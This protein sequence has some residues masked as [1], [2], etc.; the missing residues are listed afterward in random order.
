MA[1]SLRILEGIVL[2]T[3]YEGDNDFV[4]FQL[5]GETGQ[6]VTVIGNKK[7]I[8]SGETLRCNGDWV[9]HSRYGLQFKASSIDKIFKSINQDTPVVLKKDNLAKEGYPCLPNDV[10]VN[11]R[12]QV[13]LSDCN[14]KQNR[15][16]EKNRQKLSHPSR[17]DSLRQLGVG[18]KTA[19]RILDYF[20]DQV[21]NVIDKDPYALTRIAGI[22][23][24][25]ADRIALSYGLDPEDSKRVM[26][27]LRFI[28]EEAAKAGST[29]MLLEKLIEKTAI[30]TGLTAEKIAM[31]LL[32]GLGEKMLVG[33]M[34]GSGWC[35]GLPVLSELEEKIAQNIIAR[36]SRPQTGPDGSLFA[37]LKQNTLW[38]HTLD[39]IASHLSVLQRQAVMMAMQENV[40]IITGGPGTG[41]STLIGALVSLAHSLCE[42]VVVCAP[43][44]RA[45]KRLQETTGLGAK[46]I[47]RL[48]GQAQRRIEADLVIIDEASMLDIYLAAKLLQA[49]P[50]QT[51]MV[52]V[53]DSDQLPS[54][55]PG[56]VF[57]D[58]IDAK[59]FPVFKL[60]EVFRQG[61]G[62]PIIRA[63]HQVNRGEMPV[64]EDSQE[65]TWI[66]S[67]RA[68]QTLE[69]LLKAFALLREEGF[70]DD[71]I[72][73]LSPLH[74]GLLGCRHLNDIFQEVINPKGQVLLIGAKSFRTGERVM[75][76]INN[77]ELELYNGDMGRILGLQDDCLRAVFDD[78]E[79]LLPEKHCHHLQQAYCASVHRV[80]GSEFPAVIF[81]VVSAHAGILC[82]NLV[83][84]AM[85]RAKKRL[86]LI[87]EKRALW[88]A[89]RNYF[90]DERT[91]GLGAAMMKQD[92]VCVWNGS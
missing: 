55:G 43:T 20:G 56:R 39:Q 17:Y 73:L 45:A 28:L 16:K 60:T 2:K 88:L 59:T 77:Y 62:S 52:F 81:P 90:K 23:F 13:K 8:V 53:G 66:E 49:L 92:E 32:N 80:Q 64:F 4:V 83:Y 82:K 18:P 68:E 3:I 5:I 41:K 85:T 47:H 65:L 51:R 74:K 7:N 44:G 36:M 38:K 58:M 54:V 1:L 29:M 33:R 24:R 91:T 26:A 78:R 35:I 79:L 42:T 11:L 19:E 40:S 27:A 67:R 87:G 89:V 15:V 34:I 48:L 46:T 25:V 31:P 9:Q 63:A 10:E 12:S 6:P 61:K 69:M 37:S 50:L 14:G 76:T 71:E 86:I 22:G 21:V 75:Q 84:T 70:G 72:Q 57:A 30:L